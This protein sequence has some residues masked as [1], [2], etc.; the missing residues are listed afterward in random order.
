MRLKLLLITFALIVIYGY[1]C[2][3]NI[4]TELQRKSV[5]IENF[6][7]IHCG[8]CP[9]GHTIT[10]DLLVAQPGK[11]FT[12]AI[13]AG[14]FAIPGSDEPD[15]RVEDA[16]AINTEFG[17]DSYGY[18]CGSINRETIEG[19]MVLGR[20]AWTKVSKSEHSE[21]APVNL[22]LNSTYNGENRELKISVEGYY[23][24][25][26]EDDNHYLSVFFMENYI[27]G[28]QSGGGVGSDYVHMHMLRDYITDVWGDEIIAPAKGTS[29]K[30]EYTYTLPETILEVPVKAENIELIAFVSKSK[31]EILN[32]T[33][34]KPDYVNL[35]KPLGA[36]LS[37]PEMSIGAKYAYNYFDV[38]LKNESNV[39]IEKAEFKITINGNEQVREWTGYIHSFENLPIRISTDSYE[40]ESSNTYSIELISLN[41]E[42]FAG[43]SIKG[44]FANLYETTPKILLELQTDRHADENSYLIKDRNGNIVHEFGPY[45]TGK[46]VVYEEEISLERDQVYCLEITDDWA[47]GIQDP[48]GAVKLFTEDNVMVVQDFNIQKYGSRYFF[49]TSLHP[50]NLDTCDKDASNCY[51]NREQQQIELTLSGD[52]H[53]FVSVYTANGQLV[54]QSSLV[55]AYK[56]IPTGSL[57]TGCYI[58]KIQQET[59]TKTYKILIY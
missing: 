39:P 20:S 37:K 19:T 58:L 24:M 49:K 4:S 15:Y 18:P 22:L 59:T 11:V 38:Q 51:V 50:S 32:V 57:P 2:G 31:K 6:T 9:Q 10:H 27:K 29:F 28:P 40:V 23:T 35:E 26:V 16:V 43:N 33:G 36:V 45:A 17:I 13:H 8:Y 34:N 53:A 25:D 46:K 41:G 14:I 5:L 48:R 1:V 54:Y 3:Q 44:S 21:Y 42:S 56:T 47:D 12:V 52:Q 30:K 7:G 55:G